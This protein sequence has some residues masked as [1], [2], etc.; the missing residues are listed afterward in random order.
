MKEPEDD[1]AQPRR[2][3]RAVTDEAWLRI[4]GFVTPDELVDDYRHLLASQ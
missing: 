2:R 4:E 1:L 3:D